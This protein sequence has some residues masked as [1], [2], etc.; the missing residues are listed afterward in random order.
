M[1]EY[2]DIRKTWPP[3]SLERR[4]ALRARQQPKAE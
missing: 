4:A 3:E 1:P 2:Y